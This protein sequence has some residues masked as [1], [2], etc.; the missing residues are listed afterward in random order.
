MEDF[1][2]F[3]YSDE[4]HTFIRLSDVNEICEVYV[5]ENEDEGPGSYATMVIHYPSDVQRLRMDE[6]FE[7]TFI[8]HHL[9]QLCAAYA[10]FF[11]VFDEAMYKIHETAW[12]TLIRHF[13]F[14]CVRY[15]SGN[16]RTKKGGVTL[17][18][19]S[20]RM[21]L[22]GNLRTL[23]HAIAEHAVYL[24][25]ITLNETFY[26]VFES[27]AFRQ[28]FQRVPVVLVE[29]PWSI[30]RQQKKLRHQLIQLQLSGSNL[31]SFVWETLRVRG[32]T[33]SLL[34]VGN[35]SDPTL[36]W[37]EVFCTPNLDALYVYTL[38]NSLYNVQSKGNFI[39][40]PELRYLYTMEDCK[41]PTLNLVKYR[42]EFFHRYTFPVL[43]NFMILIVPMDMYL[44]PLKRRQMRKQQDAIME[45]M[46][47]TN[48]EIVKKNKYTLMHL[49]TLPEYVDNW[50]NEAVSNGIGYLCMFREFASFSTVV[51][52]MNRRIKRSVYRKCGKK[53]ERQLE[54]HLAK[55]CFG[56]FDAIR[57]W[58]N[59]DV[60]YELPK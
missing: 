49:H 47:K 31:W 19:P 4:L 32:S 2:F 15:F 27:S 20:P 39:V 12:F 60:L 16:Q 55:L 3:T 40:S 51:R 52:W 5:H 46:N 42:Y 24:Q 58:A 48:M 18:E 59:T 54:H 45:Y 29:S 13:P 22:Y 34:V 53:L 56:G 7:A 26:S 23:L 14:Q 41:E 37:N 43:Q 36:F 30:V 33:Y 57:N 1:N 28:L 6:T 9:P 50:Q 8:R 10:V 25:I 35:I 21:N 44:Y 11:R 38:G 17:L